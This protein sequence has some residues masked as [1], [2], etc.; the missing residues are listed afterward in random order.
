MPGAQRELNQSKTREERVMS[1]IAITVDC[2]ADELDVLA[3]FWTAALGYDQ[4]LPGYLVDPDGVC[5]RIAL[6]VV[7]EPKTVK[8]RWHLDV[9]VDNL[10]ALQPKVD[11]LVWLGTNV[12]R[13]VDEVS[14]GYTDVFT[15]MLDPCGNE[16]CVCAPHVRV[17]DGATLESNS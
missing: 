9:Y 8:N 5:P 3:E 11:A 4:M 10:E 17:G 15:A 13:R 12:V 2:G 16:F 7:P 1:T 14:N 6:E